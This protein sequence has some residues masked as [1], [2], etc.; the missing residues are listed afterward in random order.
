MMVCSPSSVASERV[1]LAEP[2]M[3]LAAIWRHPVKSLQGEQLSNAEVENDGVR[4]DRCWGIRDERTDKI[5]TARR[6]PQLLH[7]A[8]ALGQSGQPELSLP[9]GTRCLGV[10]ATTDAALSAWLGRPVSLVPAATSQGAT[11]EY[12][13]D[14]TD[15]DS[16]A[17]EWT[18]PVGRFVDNMPVLLLTTAS[19]RAGSVSHPGGCW[20]VRRFRPNLLVEVE[21]DEWLEDSWC[22]QTVRVGEVELVPRQ[23]CVRCTMVTR[24]QPGLERDLEIYR[25]LA[26][27]HGS[28]LGVWA[29]VRTPGSVNVG[30]PVRVLS[31]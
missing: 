18:M 8:A 17:R 14:A 4:S 30:D 21:G 11:A 19:L 27:D 24:A 2:T 10:G 25:S 7:A 5:L 23:P 15:D 20:D 22:H 9:H 26:R 3:K 13:A 28:N 1:V 31:T 6:E 12:F 16:P 29:T